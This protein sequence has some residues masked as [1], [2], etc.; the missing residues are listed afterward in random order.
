MNLDNPYDPEDPRYDE[1][2]DDEESV[3]V[4]DLL[5]IDP[6]DAAAHE[7]YLRVYGGGPVPVPSQN[8]GQVHGE[9][10]WAGGSLVWNAVDWSM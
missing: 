10:R 3:P 5:V 8:G 9:G 4:S 6:D 7:E 1:Y 2:W